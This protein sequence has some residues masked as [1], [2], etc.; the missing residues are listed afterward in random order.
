MGFATCSIITVNEMEILFELVFTFLTKYF[1][2]FFISSKF[3]LRL[4]DPFHLLGPR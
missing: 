1:G 4:L 3:N 2:G